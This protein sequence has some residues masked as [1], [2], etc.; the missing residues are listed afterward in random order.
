MLE[1]IDRLLERIG[2]QKNE[3]LKEE[4]LKRIGYVNHQIEEYG[5]LASGTTKDLAVAFQNVLGNRSVFQSHLTLEDWLSEQLRR[6]TRQNLHRIRPT[7]SFS[8]LFQRLKGEKMRV[9]LST[10]DD[11]V[12]T[13]LSLKQLGIYSFFDFIGTSDRYKGKPDPEMFSAFCEKLG[14]AASEVAVVGDT[15]TDLLFAR[16]GG[17]GLV[18]G[19]LSGVGNKEVLE[20]E[21]DFLLP[22]VSGLI[23]ADGR[24]IWDGV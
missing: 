1:V 23:R 13:I 3:G 17:A 4:L 16:N 2:A 5:I 8:N 19:V 15:V 22:S 12:A 11:Y 6:L 14:L 24:F 18:I 7:A 9:G 20:K 21:A 10:A